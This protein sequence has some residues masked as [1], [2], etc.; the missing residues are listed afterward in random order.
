MALTGVGVCND[1]R[2]ALQYDG[3]ERAPDEII[4]VAQRTWLGNRASPGTPAAIM[5]ALGYDLYLTRGLAPS[6]GER[7]RQLLQ[8]DGAKEAIKAVY[9]LL[10]AGLLFWLGWKR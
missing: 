1:C 6:L 5:A 10:L 7:A 8:E 3:L 4:G 2:A 9:A